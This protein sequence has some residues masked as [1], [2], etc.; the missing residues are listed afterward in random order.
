MEQLDER[1][2]EHL[3]EE[4][5]STPSVM[6]SCPEFGASQGRIDE[7]CRMLA[8]AGFVY[9]FHADMYELTTWGR[10]Y[11]DGELDAHH[12]PTPSVDRVLRG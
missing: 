4:D 1:I 7:R 3:R 10:L 5:W 11:L 8:Y 9:A 12:Q 2:L 6:A